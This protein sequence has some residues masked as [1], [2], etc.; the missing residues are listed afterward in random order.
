MVAR[1]TLILS[2]LTFLL[3]A[4]S[5]LLLYQT[6]LAAFILTFIYLPLYTIAAKLFRGCNA[7]F[8]LSNLI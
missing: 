1:I 2:A 8:I 6:K 4:F 5:N 3:N 7:S